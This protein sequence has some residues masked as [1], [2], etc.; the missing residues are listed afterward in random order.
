MPNLAILD[1]FITK[2]VANMATHW[3]VIFSTILIQGFT[4]KFANHLHLSWASIVVC[5]VLSQKYHSILSAFL[6]PYL[7]IAQLSASQIHYQEED[8]MSSYIFLVHLVFFHMPLYAHFSLE[9][10]LIKSYVPLLLLL[11]C[12]KLREEYN[13]QY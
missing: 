13:F 8:R 3:K 6:S 11:I 9:I 1:T 4:Y 7:S 5:I 2:S 12:L 10:V